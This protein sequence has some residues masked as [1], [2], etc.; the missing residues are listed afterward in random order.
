MLRSQKMRLAGPEVDPLWLGTGRTINELSKPQILI[1]TTFG[2]SHPGSKHLNILA[3]SA[4]NS[5]YSANAMPSVYTVTDICDGVATGHSGMNYSLVS[6]EVIAAMVE[7]HART[8]SFDGLIT[9]SSCDKAIPAHLIALA[10]LDLPGIHISGGSMMPGPSFISADK[11]YETNMRVAEGNMSEKEEWY[12]KKN[13]CPSA[14]ACQYMGTASTMQVMAE[15]LGMT[16]PSNALVPATSNMINQIAAE[17][18]TLVVE[19]VKHNITPR[20]IMT[21]A[22][23]NNAIMIHAAIGGSTNAVLHLPAI[24]KELGID[25]KYD[26]F[27]ELSEGIPLLTRIMTAGKWPTQFFWYAGGVPRV[28]MELK[29][30]L[31]FDVLTVTGKSLGENLQELE[32]TGYFRRCEEYLR[33]FNLHSSD[34]IKSVKKPEDLDSGI[35]I[36]KGNIAPEG[37]VIKHC[38]VDKSMYYFV[39][40]ARI[41]DTEEDAID[42]IYNDKILPGDI[43]VIRYKGVKAAGMPEMLKAT[44]AICN[45]P[46]LNL[47]T[48]LLT[49]GRFSGASRGPSV[50]YIRPEAANGG[51]IGLL[52]NGDLIEIDIKKRGLNIIGI[53]GVECSVDKIQYELEKR[54]K[55]NIQKEF[56]HIGALKFLNE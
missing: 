36:L 29:D 32:N 37:A 55:N 6:R 40:R 54:R 56:K 16:I 44:D 15:T 21:R 47:T 24:A 9:V 14:G 27:Q 25:L 11:C 2:D 1:D 46:L 43:V 13:A 49:D 7:I 3:E 51:P 8:S 35:T 20:K 31:N 50:G 4:K 5:V 23:F 41:Y 12:Y 53:N 30:F 42:E 26:D 39:G 33:N 19:L 34:I 17:A 45:K 28:M 22:S 10:R 38:A 18:G 48:A 52:D